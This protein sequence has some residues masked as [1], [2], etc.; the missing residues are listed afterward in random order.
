MRRKTYKV[1]ITFIL[2]NREY[3]VITAYQLDYFSSKYFTGVYSINKVASLDRKFLK[4]DIIYTGKFEDGY[5]LKKNIENCFQE[6][7][8]SFEYMTYIKG[9]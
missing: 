8:I 1:K 7:V 4:Y 2:W 5:K 9:E 3:E 6:N